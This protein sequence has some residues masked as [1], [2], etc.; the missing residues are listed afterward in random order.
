MSDAASTRYLLTLMDHH[1]TCCLRAA[2]KGAGAQELAEK[3]ED[4]K[5][6]SM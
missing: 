2:K 5:E 4:E 1:R 3:E 6:G